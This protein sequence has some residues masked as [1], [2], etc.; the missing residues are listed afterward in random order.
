MDVL[1]MTHSIGGNKTTIIRNYTNIQSLTDYVMEFYE[2]IGFQNA[3]IIKGIYDE[4]VTI[5]PS[6]LAADFSYKNNKPESVKFRSNGYLIAE[7]D[8]QKD[9]DVKEFVE[10]YFG[11]LY[12]NINF[13]IDYPSKISIT[14]K[15]SFLGDKHMDFLP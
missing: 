6:K 8:K 4:P 1:K 11:L 10:M 15:N 2:L 5:Q 7:N 12:N 13:E 14:I 9:L 3:L